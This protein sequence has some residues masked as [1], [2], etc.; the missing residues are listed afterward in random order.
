[1]T[2]RPS[3]R[4][5]HVRGALVR[6]AGFVLALACALTAVTP[7]P[8]ISATA[9]TIVSVDV[10]GNV[11]VPT[12]TILSVVQAKPGQPYNPQ[13]VQGDLQRIFALG[14]F[15]DQA[16]P[17]IRQ[18]PG[19]VAITYRV[20]ENPVITKIVFTG[21]TH[22]PSDTLLALMD[23][24]VGQVLNTNTLK[25]DFLKINSYY[26]RIGYGG[27]LPTHVKNLDID[28]KTGTL[29]ID[30]QEGLTISKVEIG[31]DPLLPP[32]VI[33]PTLEAK[34][35][36]EYSDALRDKDFQNLQKLYQKYDLVLAN[37]DGGIDPS[38]IDQK[39]GTAVVKYD[40]YVARVG[41]IQITG[42]TKTK[43]QVI[44]RQLS[45]RPGM[46]I[47]TSAIRRDQERL[48]NTGFF[49][50]VD[51]NVKEGP[52]PKN[53]P[54]YLTLDWNVTEQRTA[55][56][57][58]GAGYSGGITGQGLYGTVGYQD[59][60]LHGTGNGVSLQ[61][62]RGARSFTTQASVTI[63]YVGN[64]PQ[65]QKYSFG[66]T[67]FSNGTTYY[68]P[69]YST[70]NGTAA[71]AP[72]TATAPI[73]VTLLPSGSAQLINGV[74]S[75]STAKASGASVTVGRRLTD[76]IQASVGVNAES[77][78][79]STTVPSPYFFSNNQPNVITGPTPGPLSNLNSG[80]G[81]F[82]INATSIANINTGAPYRLNSV[83]FGIGTNP[84]AT[85]DDI[86]NPRRGE[87]AQLTEEVSSP[88]FGSNFS[89]TET[90]LDLTKFLP[91]LKDATL[92]FH[93]Q[94]Q[95]SSGAIPPSKLFTFSDQQLRGYN[96]VFYGT[97][98]VLGQIELRQPITPDRKFAVALFV[99]EGGFRVR[100]AQPLLDPYTNRIIG[101]PGNWAY[102][103]DFGF[104]LRF[105]VPQLGLHTIRID[106]AR[107]SNGTHTSFGI[108]Q[109]F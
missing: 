80:T 15:A 47:T 45:L 7:V 12:Q 48:N 105:D 79:N 64:T 18:R 37:A 87:T 11:H 46:V 10:S 68:Y 75:T 34:P 32:N 63:P 36:V 8:A 30:I 22:V 94:M 33:L 27:Q 81:S 85:L 9:P 58:I 52:D 16:T 101:Y 96:S 6:C 54:G 3:T 100:G 84:A 65:S 39:A 107:G 98:T 90:T 108:G 2:S 17:L 71:P 70:V 24:S 104:G 89:Y 99:D 93:A 28:P 62:E 72:G 44:R 49:S 82:G 20:I 73:P 61:F 42:N 51:L 50:K 60:N 14:Y 23:T 77:V 66:A 56:A 86:F 4:S 103:G 91:V 38:T 78:T 5:G 106:F 41:A 53:H 109:S 59:N 40:L 57:S 43:D 97:D 25:Q 69:V 31:G 19:G 35:G 55:T 95:A 21:N 1:M 102:R 88:S 29:T 67:I 13:V 26:D 74:V 83:V 92:G 76:F